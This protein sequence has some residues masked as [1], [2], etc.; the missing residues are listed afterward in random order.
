MSHLSVGRYHCAGHRIDACHFA[1][2]TTTLSAVNALSGDFAECRCDVG[3]QI[4]L[5]AETTIGYHAHGVILL[6]HSEIVWVL[7]YWRRRV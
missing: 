5:E 7:C 6:T 3:L 4:S 2:T 1:H